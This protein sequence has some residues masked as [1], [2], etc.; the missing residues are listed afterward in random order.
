MN[1]WILDIEKFGKIEDASIEVSPFMVFVGDNNSGKSYVMEL[2]WG[3]IKE[4]DI[5]VAQF[6]TQDKFNEFITAQLPL[7]EKDEKDEIFFEGTVSQDVQNSLLDFFNDGFESYREEFIRKLFNF[8]VDSKKIR[9]RK[10]SKHFDIKFKSKKHEVFLNKGENKNEVKKELL[11]ITEIYLDDKLLTNGIVHKYHNDKIYYEILKRVYVTALLCLIRK[12]YYN[13]LDS[14]AFFFTEDYSSE[15]I[16]F[17]A[18]RTGYLHTYRAIIGNQRPVFEM[19]DDVNKPRLSNNKSKNQILG[20]SL[21]LPTISFL[22]KLQ[23]LTYDDEQGKKYRDEVDFLTGNILEGE[24]IRSQAETFEFKSNNSEKSIPLHATSSLISEL[25]PLYMFLN[26]S[27]DPD[28]WIIEEIESHLHPKIQIEVIRFLVR[29]YN[30]GKSVWITTHSDNLIQRIN[31]IFTLSIIQNSEELLDKVGFIKSDI[32]KN[33][34]DINVYQFTCTDGKSFIE[35][36]EPSDFGFELSTFNCILEK[37]IKETYNIQI[38]EE[39]I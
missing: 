1:K 24:I 31:N 34:E 14:D 32:L 9:I 18:S 11:V 10:K 25:A 38:G 6:S 39:E 35:K 5:I 36:L 37:L 15:P 2:L 22:N 20:T 27:Y 26:S 12:D 33:A 4:A 7:N 8:N 16:Y 30:K 17:P 3:I 13:K 21:T 19:F 23:K 29:L 28:L